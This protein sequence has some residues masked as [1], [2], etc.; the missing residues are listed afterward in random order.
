MR[1]KKRRFNPRPTIPVVAYTWESQKRQF[2]AEGEPGIGYF[3]GETKLGVVH[4]LLYRS[5][6]GHVVG[7]LYYYDRD[8]G[9]WEKAGNVN[10]LVD[11]AFQRKGIAMELLEEGERRY[12]KFNFEQQDYTVEGAALAKAYL[13]R[14][15]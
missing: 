8:F 15:G 2:P 3:A 14:R 1:S 12:G 13:R 6:E 4:T 11:P 5:W 9:P 7:I 10:L